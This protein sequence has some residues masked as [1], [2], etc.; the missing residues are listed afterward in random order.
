G[1]AALVGWAFTM[2]G[3][4]TE[5]LPLEVRADT[6]HEL[7]A[8]LALTLVLLL[9]L[10][11]AAGFLSAERPASPEAKRLAGR[12]LLGVVAAIPVVLLI[13]LATA[14]GGIDGQVS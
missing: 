11:L 7:G 3:L 13:A 14:P 9:A 10:G 1:A 12:V 4:T 6:G 5:R 2:T 8:L